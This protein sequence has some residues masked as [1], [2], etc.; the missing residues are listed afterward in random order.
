MVATSAFPWGL[1]P[2]FTLQ[3]IIDATA[4][5]AILSHVRHH[6]EERRG[7]MMEAET[8][9]HLQICSQPARFPRGANHLTFS[10]A[11]CKQATGMPLTF[12]LSE[13]VCLL[14][15]L[16]SL[17]SPGI[18][19]QKLNA[20]REQLTT[21]NI[22]HFVHWSSKEFMSYFGCCVHIKTNIY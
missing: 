17:V 5:A 7:G 13:T 21:S 3:L 19:F 22:N 18:F 2:F 15:S 1:A 20:S 16:S 14:L 9:R 4:H 10:Y 11:S 8:R 12:I 6:R